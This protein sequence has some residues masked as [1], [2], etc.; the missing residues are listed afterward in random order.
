[1]VRLY[2]QKNCYSA[3][4]NAQA[5][6]TGRTHYVDDETLKWHHSRVL[7]AGHTDQGLLFYILTSDALD[8]H[9]T[10]RGYRYVIFDVFGHV[11]GRPKLEDAFRTKEQARK[12][13][14]VALNAIDAKALTLEAIETERKYFMR[15]MEDLTRTVNRQ[16]TIA[17]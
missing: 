6:L 14:W 17:A 7:S 3:K 11:I 12:A 15:D 1:M 5:N 8:M 10:K 9:N 16:E 4:L 13:M 2:E